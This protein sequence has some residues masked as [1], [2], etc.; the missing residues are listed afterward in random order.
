[1]PV[2][3]EDLA[4]GFET[5]VRD[6]MDDKAARRRP[7]QLFVADGATVGCRRSHPACLVRAGPLP[8]G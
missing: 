2:R 3:G 1:M 6:G 4:A 7:I 8:R 5:R